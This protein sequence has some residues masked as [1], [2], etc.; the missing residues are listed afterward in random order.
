MSER[1]EGSARARAAGLVGTP[2]LDALRALLQAGT[3]M[4]RAIARRAGLSHSEL[5]TLDHL[6]A[7]PIGPA[8]VARLLDVTTAA[9]TGIVDRM[10]S[11]GHAERHRHPG[12]G[13]RVD[14][15]L[16]DS[17]REEILGHLM[18]VFVELARHDASFTDAE[19]EVVLRYLEGARHAITTA[20]AAAAEGGGPEGGGA[21]R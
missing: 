3:A 7:G 8:D 5:Q 11:R 17:G 12:D 2:T 16:T 4:R 9:A 20:T 6:S 15:H 21:P 19:R 10:V 14:V 1:A 18:P 13:R